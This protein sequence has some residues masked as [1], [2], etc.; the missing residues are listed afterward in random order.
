MHEIVVCGVEFVKA[1]VCEQHLPQCVVTVRASPWSLDRCDVSR[2]CDGRAQSCQG[3]E[4]T[5]LMGIM[6]K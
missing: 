5:Y 3:A 4:F 6:D 2:L 1:L